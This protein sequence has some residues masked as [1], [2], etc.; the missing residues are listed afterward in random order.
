MSDNKH[1]LL[2]NRARAGDTI[3]VAGADERQRVLN[4][5]NQW[6]KGKLGSFRAKSEWT[7]AGYVI[8]FLGQHPN[9]ALRAQN[10]AAHG[11]DEI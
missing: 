7:S 1:T 8:T 3:T 2:F 5:F 6:R 9:E 11:S 4:S 10:A